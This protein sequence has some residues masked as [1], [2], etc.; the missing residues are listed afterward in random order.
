[1]GMQRNNSNNIANEFTESSYYQNKYKELS[2]FDDE[3][4]ND[5]T[6]LIIH[7]YDRSPN[8]SPHNFDDQLKMMERSKTTFTLLSTSSRGGDSRRNSTSSLG[9]ITTDEPG[10]NEEIATTRL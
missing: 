10:S 9:S 2:D 3:S 8:A 6:K 7:K 1:M 5:N 4:L